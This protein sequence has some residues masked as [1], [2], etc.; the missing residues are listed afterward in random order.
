VNRDHASGSSIQHLKYRI[1]RIYGLLSC[2][3]LRAD[4]ANLQHKQAKRVAV[5][6]NA[7]SYAE[8]G[9]VQGVCA[10]SAH[11]IAFLTPIV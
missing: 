4:N 10:V 6:P 1:H 9:L 8:V 2:P 5:S 3:K 7:V 11:H